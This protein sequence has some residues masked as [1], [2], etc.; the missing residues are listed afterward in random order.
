MC[1]ICMVTF[2][3]QA[4]AQTSKAL[5]APGFEFIEG[6]NDVGG[7][8]AT[9]QAISVGEFVS[10]T[11]A[12]DG[13]IDMFEITLEEGGTYTF[14]VLADDANGSALGDSLLTL[15]DSADNLVLQNDDSG[16]G[17]GDEPGPNAYN[18]LITFTVGAGGGGTYYLAVDESDLSPLTGYAQTGDYLLQTSGGT[19]EDDHGND[20]ASAQAITVGTPVSGTIEVSGDQDMFAVQLEAGKYYEISQLTD[21]ANGSGLSDSYLYLYDAAGTLITQND[22]AVGTQA[23]IGFAATESGTYYIQADAYGSNTGD[24]T[25]TVEEAAAPP[26]SSPLDALDWNYTAPTTINVYLPAVDHTVDD[27]ISDANAGIQSGPYI[28]GA[29]T[30][31]ETAAVMMALAEYESV[32]DVDFQI[33]TTMA[34]ADFAFFFS[35][36]KIEPAPS[37]GYVTGYWGIGGGIIT[38][39]GT[40]HT[41]DGWTVMNTAFP[42]YSEASMQQGGQS[43]QTL[44]H[45]LGHGMGMAHPHDTGGGS[46]VMNGVTSSGSTG[47]YGLNQNVW[48]VMSYN[49]GWEGNPAGNSTNGTYGTAGGLMALDIAYLQSVYG[50]NETT[51]GGN[52]TYLLDDT[53]GS[54]TWYA[55]IWD[56]GGTDRI[57]AGGYTTD[58]VI[59]LRAATLDYSPTGG[60]MV[61]YVGGV[62]GGFTIAAGV[63]IENAVGGSGNDEM[64]GNDAE[65]ILLGGLGNDEISGGAGNDTL[66]GNAGEDVING[67]AG[68]DT[69]NGGGDNDTIYGGDGADDVKGQTGADTIFG[70]DGDDVIN[71]QSGDDILYGDAGND[72]IYGLNNEDTMYGGE[73]NDYLSGGGSAD[74]IFGNAGEDDING[75]V[76]HD[77]I[78]GGDDDDI[79]RGVDGNDTLN[80]DAGN[81]TIYGGRGVDLIDGGTG[82]DTI[83]GGDQNDIIYGGDGIDTIRGGDGSD[84]LVG[85]SGNDKLYGQAGRDTFA[86]FDN[87]WGADRIFD[88][89]DGLDRIQFGANTGISSMSDLSITDV[90]GDAVISLVSDPTQTITVLDAA[91]KIDASDIDLPVSFD[92]QTLQNERALD[93][94]EIA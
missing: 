38:V 4:E 16:I 81:D 8:Y 92:F 93:L 11:I 48:T 90:N 5:F 88:W 40:D 73:G 61:S 76:G 35:D 14:S 80:G 72:E 6:A 46:A 87:Q 71:G 52:N 68:N 32:I 64:T 13:D 43:Y 33:V 66:N 2:G 30:A 58:V 86:Y 17:D 82:N 85:G 79:I 53:N 10:A 39:D 89:Q 60:G 49:D 9:A 47:D 42:G 51:N 34:E 67:D 70:N 26:P 63:V 45:E 22:D 36:D 62:Q 3:K 20:I 19:Y 59:D 12:D 74:T 7:T 77:T 44:L 15:Y 50:A 24:Y 31:Y 29:L 25:L 27:G 23:Q 1:G 65:N 91:G 57:Y 94:M 75:G 54:G 55:A 69:I 78:N 56:T 28:A 37:G 84:F 41:V 83:N 21:N 18:S